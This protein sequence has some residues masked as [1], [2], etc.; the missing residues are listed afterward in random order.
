MNSAAEC[1]LLAIKECLHSF[2]D[3]TTTWIVNKM[4]RAQTLQRNTTGPKTVGE[5]A[6]EM[7]RAFLVTLECDQLA[8]VVSIPNDATEDEVKKVA[9]QL[10]NIIIESE[11]VDTRNVKTWSE[12]ISFYQRVVNGTISPSEA[13]EQKRMELNSR[14]DQLETDIQW[15]K[16]RSFNC[17]IASAAIGWIQMANTLTGLDLGLAPTVV[18]SKTRINVLQVKLSKVENELT[19]FNTHVNTRDSVIAV[20]DARKLL[21]RM[22]VINLTHFQS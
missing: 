4:P 21:D 15:H 6:E 16:N 5:C 18:D 12:K 10:Y 1:A 8:N 17:S 11:T 7:K 22:S 14:R 2:T 3:A 20:E 19:E 13:R 9:D